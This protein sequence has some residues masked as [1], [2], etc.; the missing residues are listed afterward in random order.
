[1]VGWLSAQIPYLGKLLFLR[2]MCKISRPIRYLDFSNYY[3]FWTVSLYFIF[4]CIKVEYH[5]TFKMLLS[6]FW[7]NAFI[8]PKKGKK[9][10]KWVG[11]LDKIN[12]FVN[13]SK[14]VHSFFLVFF[15]LFFLLFFVFILF[16]F[17]FSFSFFYCFLFCFLFQKFRG[18]FVFYACYYW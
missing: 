10:Q 17:F 12:F 1:M 8:P 3:I 5:K 18:S 9:E 4:F 7:K 14:L 16:S 2:F 13:C 6:L 11:Q 15:S